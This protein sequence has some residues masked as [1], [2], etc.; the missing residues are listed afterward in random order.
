[1]KLYPLFH[2][3]AFTKEVYRF[4][5][6]CIYCDGR[7]QVQ[8]TLKAPQPPTASA[9]H[10]GHLTDS[11]YTASCPIIAP[12]HYNESTCESTSPCCGWCQASCETS[13]AQQGV[14]AK[15][16]IVASVRWK[17]GSVDECVS[18]SHSQSWKC[19][20]STMEICA[21]FILFEAC[22]RD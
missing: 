22:R 21:L 17:I 3:L 19:P 4:T 14:Y 5:P 10:D 6:C 2:N 20:R 7:F 12:S 13:V 1:M 16:Q 9:S 11:Y 18:H 8:Q 15:T